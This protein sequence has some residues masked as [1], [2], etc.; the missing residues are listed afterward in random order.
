[1]EVVKRGRQGIWEAVRKPL[2]KDVAYSMPDIY[3]NKGP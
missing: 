3:H 2:N 1:M